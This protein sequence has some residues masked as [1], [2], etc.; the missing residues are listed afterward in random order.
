MFPP[1][2]SKKHLIRKTIFL[3][4]FLLSF[5][6]VTFSKEKTKVKKGKNIFKGGEVVVRGQKETSNIE[7]AS[8]S[9]TISEEDIKIHNDRS[10]DEAL[11]NLPGIVIEPHN[12]GHLRFKL[13]G[14]TQEHLAIFIDGIPVNDVFST[15]VDV[16]NFLVNNASK[17]VINKGTS[18]ALYGTRGPLGSVNIVTS[19]PNRL[20]MESNIE[21]G[22]HRNY[23]L[24]IAQGAALKNFYYWLTGS[25]INSGGY[26]ASKKLNKKKRQ[27]WVDKF[28]KYQWYPR[29]STGEN[30]TSETI[31]IPALE[32]YL[33]DD[34]IIN[35]TNYKKYNLDGKFSYQIKPKAEIGLN[36]RFFYK[37]SKTSTY[38]HN[39]FS[40][41]KEADHIWEDPLFE[42]LEED[43][44]K[45]IAFRNRSFEWLGMYD[46]NI[47]PFFNI[48]LDNFFLQGNLFYSVRQSRQNGYATNDHKY[49]K[50]AAAG[51]FYEPFTDKKTFNSYGFNLYPSWQVAT[52]NRLSLA[53]LWHQAFY[54]NEEKALSTEESPNIVKHLGSDFYPIMDMKISYTS[55]ALEDEALFLKEKLKITVGI[56][57]DVQNFSKYKNRHDVYIY[58]EAYIVKD[59]TLFW[60]TRD[61]FNPVAGLT[62]TPWKNLLF[63]MSGSIKTRFPSLSEY[64]KVIEDDY[65]YKL[66]SERSYNANVGAETSFLKKSLGFKIDFFR[67]TI[68]DRIAKIAGGSEPPVNIKEVRSQGFE[69]SLSLNKNNLFSLVDFNSQIFY[70]YLQARNKDNSWEEKVNKGKK[71][72]KTPEHQFGFDFR[73]T[74]V[75]KTNLIFWGN[76]SYNQI[77][78]AMSSRPEAN[79]ENVPFSTDFFKEVKLHNPIMLNFKI[80]QQIGNN[81]KVYAKAKNILDDYNPDPFNPGPGRS[82][83]FGLTTE[84]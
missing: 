46:Y 5:Q 13:R 30:Y 16:S 39:C 60:G 20:F 37:K 61:S 47:S 57:Y 21:Y 26:E 25:I 9:C 29:P 44:V 72:E 18:S 55:L 17:I 23:L 43:D 77:M 40:D 83:S 28:L 56:S 22:P 3:G 35:H 8:N 62:F 10:L 84:F 34:G 74:F 36:N 53:L 31:Y 64:S 42:I 27:E 1:F 75:T 45:K 65:D 63:K 50:D 58:E 15:D 82:F 32:Q 2:S 70:T 73:L 6:I 80:S 81:F 19:K 67:N 38:Q 69:T 12:K 59:D 33:N 76:S 14:F 4:L 11:A 54:K 79:N 66:K 51:Y 78:Y 7:K 71:L 48:N 52:W 24:N 68:K 41:Y 49:V